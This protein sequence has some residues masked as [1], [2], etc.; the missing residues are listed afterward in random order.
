MFDELMSA[1][2]KSHLGKTGPGINSGQPAGSK[3]Q[4]A[5]GLNDGSSDSHTALAASFL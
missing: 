5:L 1:S 3:T 2:T 4:P